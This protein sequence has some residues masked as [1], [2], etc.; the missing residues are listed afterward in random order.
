MLSLLDIAERIQKGP[1]MT[2]EAWNM[3]L[4]RKM[5]EL[6]ERHQ[7]YYPK[8]APVFNL[9]DDLPNKRY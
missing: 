4:F 3:G 1:K 8:D 6:T 2:D 9:D 7:L 5:N